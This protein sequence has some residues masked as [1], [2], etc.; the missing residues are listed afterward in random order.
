MGFRVHFKVLSAFNDIFEES[1]LRISTYLYCFKS[2]TSMN[3]YC[4]LPVIFG[5]F[6]AN[7][8]FAQTDDTKNVIRSLYSESLAKGQSYKMLDYLTNKIGAR[9]SGSPQAAEAVEWGRQQ[10]EKY[11][12]DSIIMQE[13]MVPHWVRGSKEKGA[14][15]SDKLPGGEVSVPVCALGGSIATDELGI[16]AE[17][18]EVHNFDELKKLGRK[19]VEGKIVFFNRP[20]D[21]TLINA[22][23]AYSG[24]V[25]QRGSGA[26]EAAKLGAVAVI[27]RSMTLNHDDNPHTGAMHYSNEVDKI[28]AAAISTNGADLL[29]KFIK[30]DPKTGFYLR[31]SCQTL[32]D[33]KS[34][35]VI[36]V[37]NGSELPNEI[38]TVGGHLDS[39]DLGKGASD[40]GTGIV[41]SLEIL[42][43]FRTLGIKPKRTV[44][45]VLFMNEENGLRGGTK[46]F[47]EAQKDITHKYIAAVES[48]AG[49]FTPR[50]FNIDTD[51]VT[52]N[53]INNWKPLFEPYGVYDLK[54]GGSGA[55]VYQM[56]KIKAITM[57]LAPDS[58]RYFDIHHNV[59]DTLAKVN[60]RELEIG[61]AA[62]A[63]MVYLLANFGTGK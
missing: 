48:D 44:H 58:Q 45:I 30:E 11:G 15:L 47:E 8:L 50:G 56:K 1:Q 43:I 52:V 36:G 2:R 12:A 28:P 29:S 62:L 20:M 24:A 33:E 34:Y 5:L 60:P 19:N 16:K 31:M 23:E 27:V 37:I 35:N 49:G 46:Y 55:D 22:F 42:R 26:V 25:D 32:P 57:E 7:Q 59:N 39:W 38:V 9:V 17:V 54:K 10:M 63:S 21:P 13:I 6:F 4:Y 41:Q 53:M 3:K 14:I 18:V 40:D 61:A 51:Q